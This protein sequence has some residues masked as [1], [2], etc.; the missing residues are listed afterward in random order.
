MHPSA[1]R[2]LLAFYPWLASISLAAACASDPPANDAVDVEDRGP[3]GKADFIGSCQAEGDDDY[4]GGKSAGDCWCDEWCASYGDCCPDKV[5]VCDCAC[6]GSDDAPECEA[7]CNPPPVCGDGVVEGDETC[8]GDDLAGVSCESLGYT[9][10]TL[11]CAVDCT[12]DAAGCTS[13]PACEAFAGNTPEFVEQFTLDLVAPRG[14]R[15]GDLDGDGHRDLLVVSRQGA[16]D[17]LV[18]LRNDGTAAFTEVARFADRWWPQRPRIVD[19]DADGIPDLVDL[20]AHGGLAVNTRIVV[21][22][23]LG[24]FAYAA[25]VVYAVPSSNT[26]EFALADLDTDGDLDV[27]VAGQASVGVR[28]GNGNG[29]FAAQVTYAM[30]QGQA[31][32]VEVIDV[33]AN[34]ALD[35][36]VRTAT[37]VCIFP[38]AGD[39]TLVGG[40]QVCTAIGADVNDFIVGQLSADAHVDVGWVRADGSRLGLGLGGAAGVLTGT[41]G[42]IDTASQR[43]R[44]LELG[45]LDCDGNAD[46]VPYTSGTLLDAFEVHRTDGAGGLLDPVIVPLASPTALD[47]GDLDGDGADDVAVAQSRTTGVGA[48]QRVAVYR[49]TLH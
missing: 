17:G 5:A 2:R 32:G 14:V 8:D 11:A 40:A 28:M 36:V 48:V 15:I 10:G 24:G 1:P 47:L 25:P 20:G 18:L 46:L 4:C 34:A 22:R 30:G 35:V 6:D 41:L 26:R 27:V 3:L 9:G 29:T 21:R 44:S 42:E 7:V 43:A 49:T 12:L 38:G 16:D 31:R 23:G 19:L 33:D 45:D 39:G 13:G 37:G